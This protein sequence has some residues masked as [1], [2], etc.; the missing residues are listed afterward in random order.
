MLFTSEKSHAT[1]SYMQLLH[2]III[3]YMFT[4]EYKE[5]LVVYYV[6]PF[7]PEFFPPLHFHVI[8]HLFLPPSCP[9]C[10]LAVDN[11]NCSVG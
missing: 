7:I 3:L 10:F 8:P 9:L 2:S 11:E 5:C 1:L 6:I 4:P